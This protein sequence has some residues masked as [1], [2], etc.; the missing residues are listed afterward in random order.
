MER[1][2]GQKA[3][4]TVEDVVDAAA[5][6]VDRDGLGSL[7]MAGVAERIGIRS[8]SLYAHVEGLEDLRRRVAIQ[9]ARRMAAALRRSRQST[10]PGLEALRRIME[11]YRAFATAHPGLYEAAQRAVAPEEDEE[12]HAALEGVVAPA[13]SAVAE[14]GVPEEDRV[15]VV[16]AVR[17]ALHGFVSLER[18]NGF[19]I[20]V[21]VDES[22]ER[23]VSLV[24]DGV[25]AA[26]DS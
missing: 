25:P 15:H 8:P 26:T 12:L 11:D 4:L 10:P 21:S 24:L 17:A 14:A 23:L 18:V 7:S 3:G 5:A 9:A 13:M 16:R 2:A 22:F 1:K 20:P 6:M 19:G